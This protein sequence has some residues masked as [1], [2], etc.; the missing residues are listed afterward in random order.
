MTTAATA[1]EGPGPSGGPALPDTAAG[2]RLARWLAAFNAGDTGDAGALLDLYGG[3]V[4]GALAAMRATFD[5]LTRRAGG[6]SRSTGCWSPPRIASSLCSA[7][8]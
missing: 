8:R 2:R 6:R 7:P 3:L 1:A 5:L 4:P